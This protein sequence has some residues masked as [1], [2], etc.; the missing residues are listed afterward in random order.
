[1]P[2]WLGAAIGIPA[3]LLAAKAHGRQI[4]LEREREGYHSVEFG[5]TNLPFVEALWR[6]DRIRYWSVVPPVAIAL[7]AGA[8]WIEGWTLALLA[9]LLW[10]PIV[11]FHVAGLRSFA[12]TRLGGFGWWAAAMLSAG[13]SIAAG[14]A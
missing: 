2:A 5:G 11:G 1:M 4:R 12:S 7:G 9:A 8:W 10:A 6:R 14:L 13:A 3:L